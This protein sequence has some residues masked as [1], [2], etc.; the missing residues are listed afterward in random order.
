MPTHREWQAGAADLRARCE[1]AIAAATEV[2]AEAQALVEQSRQAPWREAR[3]RSAHDV[4]AL[5]T[6]VEGLRQAMATRAVIEQAKGIVMAT[7]GCSPQEAFDLLVE[8][9]Q[10]TNRKLRDVAADL[11]ATAPRRA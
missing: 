9:S 6:E 8:Q 1:A 5:R 11:V 7:A 2:V 10:H 4:A 3:P